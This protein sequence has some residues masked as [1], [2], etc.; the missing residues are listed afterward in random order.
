MKPTIRV[1]VD[2]PVELRAGDGL[3]LMPDGTVQISR[4]DDTPAL[5]RGE[6]RATVTHPAAD[7]LLRQCHLSGQMSAAQSVG[8]FGQPEH[9]PV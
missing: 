2:E 1:T 8:H 3:D 5:Q 9:H 6:I 4:D 7:E